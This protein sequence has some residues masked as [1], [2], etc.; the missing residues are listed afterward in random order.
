MGKVSFADNKIL[1]RVI[2]DRHYNARTRMYLARPLTAWPRVTPSEDTR[3][4]VAVTDDQ[5]TPV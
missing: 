4:A 2:I 5:L 3:T 1:S